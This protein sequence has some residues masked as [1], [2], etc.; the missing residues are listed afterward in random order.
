LHFEKN[1]E[2]KW[3]YLLIGLR[4]HSDTFARCSW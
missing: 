4:E 1:M 3:D 2:E